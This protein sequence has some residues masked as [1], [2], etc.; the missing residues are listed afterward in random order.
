MKYMLL[1]MGNRQEWDNLASWSKDE[2]TAMVEYMDGIN[3]ELEAS[4][5]LVEARGLAGPDQAKTVQAKPE[6]AEPIITDGPYA[7]SKEVLAGYWVVDVP[8][9]QRA[10]EIATRA[11][12]APGRGGVPVY[13]PIVVH[14]VATAPEV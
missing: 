13:Q 8:S 5:E 10:I 7:E 12:L 14:P 9:E 2:V 1:I 11:S 6:T 4:G 3:R